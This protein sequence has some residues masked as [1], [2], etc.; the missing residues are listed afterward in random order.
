M[1]PQI[2]EVGIK[3]NL[4]CPQSSVFDYSQNGEGGQPPNLV[5]CLFSTVLS[6]SIAVQNLRK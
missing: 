4:C 6:F 3:K 2:N 1:S 5:I